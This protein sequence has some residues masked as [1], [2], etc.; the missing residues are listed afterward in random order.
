V[1]QFFQQWIYRAGAPNYTVSYAYDD[2]THQIKLT[3]KQNTKSR[4]MV[5]LFDMPVDL[6]LRHR[7]A[8]KTYPL[9][10][11]KAEETFTLAA[12]SAPLMVV[13]DKGDNVLK[14]LDFKRDAA[15]LIYQLK[16]GATVPDRAEAAATL[17]TPGIRDNSGVIPALGRSGAARS[18]LG[19][20]FGVFANAGQDRRS[21]RAESRFLAR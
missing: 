12:D 7:P 11:S 20:S 2:A 5:G 18:F 9:A 19:R 15:T 1:D 14:T 16:N 3:V 8:A 6:K 21:R 13:F 17:A 10:V 4:R